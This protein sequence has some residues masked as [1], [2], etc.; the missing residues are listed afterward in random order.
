MS[1]GPDGRYG[2]QAAQKGHTPVPVTCDRC[3]EATTGPVFRGN[4]S[5]P[6]GR[7]YHGLPLTDLV[8]VFYCLPCATAT[9]LLVYGT[10]ECR[11]C[12]RSISYGGVSAQP[13]RYCTWACETSARTERRREQRELARRCRCGNCGQMFIAPRADARFCSPACKQAAYRK[14]LA[15]Q[16]ASDAYADALM[17]DYN[18]Q[19]HGG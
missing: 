4:R 7:T 6:S 16:A 13:A 17:A 15:D 19:L 12:G 10:R 14:R 2:C 1:R 9:A 5:V 18:N 11:W 8:R 3:R